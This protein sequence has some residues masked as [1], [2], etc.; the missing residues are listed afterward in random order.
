MSSSE[1]D[2]YSM[3]FASLKHPI[4]RKI[5]RILSSEAQTFSDLQKQFKIES[6]HLT[7]H[8][9]GLGNLLYKT[10]DGKYALSSLGEAAISTITKV[11]DIPTTARHQSQQT[12]PKRIIG[13]SVAIALGLICIVLIAS[14]AYFIISDISA[15]NSFNNLQNQ[16]GQLQAW[17]NGNETL[18]NQ[19]QTWLIGNGTL[20]NQTQVNN[21]NLQN[22]NANLTNQVNNLRAPNLVEVNLTA[23]VNQT[24]ISGVP[25][26]T[27]QVSGYL[28]NT[29]TN[30]AYDCEFQPIL[31]YYQNT[32]RKETVMYI[33]GPYPL[34]NLTSYSWTVLNWSITDV[35]TLINWT[36]TPAWD[37]HT[38]G[39]IMFPSFLPPAP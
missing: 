37:G 18:L 20:L 35:G 16:N 26:F 12:R 13:K 4:R 10:E 36:I 38:N 30:T 14:V 8:I 25:Y 32:I 19:T 11:E 33:L 17:L 22:Q 24:T 39:I 21:A 7:Y 27:L 31:Y 29:G 1:E 2:S 3:I 34:G 23:N 6:S 5:L 15:Q 9:D 28:F